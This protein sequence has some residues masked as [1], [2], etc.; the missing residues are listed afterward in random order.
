M[1]AK[2][3]KTNKKKGHR[4]MMDVLRDASRTKSAL[5]VYLL[6]ELQKPKFKATDIYQKLK[7]MGYE[8]VRY[9]DVTWFLK[10]YKKMDHVKNL[11]LDKGY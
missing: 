6:G 1:P 10:N 5:G 4:D 8:A 9:R 7:D 2:T 11:V 3:S